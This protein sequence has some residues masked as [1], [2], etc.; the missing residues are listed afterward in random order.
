MMNVRKGLKTESL[1]D[2]TDP[3]SEH[4]RPCRQRSPR[5]Q[6]RRGKRSTVPIARGLY[7]NSMHS[8]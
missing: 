8:L 6:L 2:S 3:Y 4:A 1:R 5:D 7:A